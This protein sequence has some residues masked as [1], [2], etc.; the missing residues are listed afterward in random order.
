MSRPAAPSAKRSNGEGSIYFD[1]AKQRWVGATTVGLDAR[2]R[3]IRRKVSGGTRQ[4]AAGKL[5]DLMQLA[6]TVDLTKRVTVGELAEEWWDAYQRTATR[7][8]TTLS[9]RRQRL[10]RHVIH[11][12]RI[13]KR[14]A[15]SL[16]VEH[17]ERWLGAKIADGYTAADGTHRDYAPSTISAIRGDLSQIMN[18]AVRRR[19][20]AHNPASHVEV[21][22]ARESAP[23]RTLTVDQAVALLG[24]CLTTEHRW[25]AYVLAVLELGARP[26][27][28]AGIRWDA[29]DDD[30]GTIRLATAVNRRTGGAAVALGPTKSK[31]SRTLTASPQL[32][33]L[34]H[35]E[36]VRQAELR[37]AAGPSWSTEWEGLVFLNRHGCPPSTSGL[38]RA[39]RVIV[40]DAGIDIPDLTVYELRHTWASLMS[41]AGLPT[42]DII[43]QLGHATTA[44]L[45]KHYRHRTDPVVRTGT[46]AWGRMVALSP[47][48]EG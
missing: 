37:L 10:E 27:E 12:S 17:V 16:R 24:A 9:V 38:R 42:H 45:F 22:P 21:A 4:E 6:G 39:L 23:K 20:V 40:A 19:R 15:E 11:D 26:G 2:G 46:E 31:Q 29:I 35:R 8:V 5:R 44:M 1:R 28:I 41:E 43:D 36:R 7:G 13:A 34:L 3:P 48:P 18:W 33:A 47:Q 25:C 14:E 32:L 30:A